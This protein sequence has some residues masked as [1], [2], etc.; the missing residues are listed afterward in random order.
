MDTKTTDPVVTPVTHTKHDS[1]EPE[2]STTESNNTETP[3]YEVRHMDTKTGGPV[4]S[5]TEDVTEY[6]VRS[7]KNADRFMSKRLPVSVYTYK[8]TAMFYLLSASLSYISRFYH[9]GFCSS[10]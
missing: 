7:S 5:T 1:V 10:C 2:I 3:L 9:I 4:I 8:V 6:P